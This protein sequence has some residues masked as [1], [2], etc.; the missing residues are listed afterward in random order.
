M[1][2]V[3]AAHPEFRMR[4]LLPVETAV[5]GPKRVEIPLAPET[6]AVV[7][8]RRLGPDRLQGESLRTLAWEKSAA[9]LAW[10]APPGKWLIFQRRSGDNLAS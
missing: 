2:L 5:D 4:R 10:D 8:G 9:T 7:V 1:D 6:A 3:V